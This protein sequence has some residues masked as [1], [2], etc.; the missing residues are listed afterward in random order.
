MRNLVAVSTLALGVVH[1]ACTTLTDAQSSRNAALWEAARSCQYGTVRVDRISNEGIPQT[2]TF[3]SGGSDFAVFRE[4]YLDRATSIWRADCAQEPE[5][6]Q[7]GTPAKASSSPSRQADALDRLFRSSIKG[8]PELSV[9][10]RRTPPGPRNFEATIVVDG[11]E[12]R[13]LT[14][15]Q[16]Q[17]ILKTIGT[18]MQES[19]RA[20]Q[21]TP[22]RNSFSAKIYDELLAEFATVVVRGPDEEISYQMYRGK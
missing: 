21:P 3:N 20:A 7:C 22:P 13:K 1:S 11:N 2:M 9:L 6:P 8:D 19:L 17:R 4:C 10:V 5:Q 14:Q 18:H 12:W 15:S 16:Q